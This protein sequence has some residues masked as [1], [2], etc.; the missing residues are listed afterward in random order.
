M[1]IGYG[2]ICRVA[3]GLLV[4][5][6]ALGLS[7]CDSTSRSQR[8]QITATVDVN[9]Q[10]YSGSA[11]QEARCRDGIKMFQSMDSAHCMLKGEAV[12]VDLKE[13]GYLFIILKIPQ[14]SDEVHYVQSILASRADFEVKDHVLR[15][16]NMPVM[17]TF[18]DVNDPKS[19][20]LVDP[21][22]FE[23]SFGKGVTLKQ[24]VVSTVKGKPITRGRVEKV[25]PWLTVMRSKRG[26]LDGTSGWD[27][28]DLANNLSH[29][30][31]I[32][33]I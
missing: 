9:G 28:N 4:L 33:G 16:E 14:D 10:S 6:A 24:V 23:D 18:K 17:V 21:E 27:K 2:F 5:S 3:T 25:L 32:S 7:A 20:A 13:R 22:H 30:D 19:V 11:V 29:I 8:Y 1:S 26:A 15:A 12:V 31:F